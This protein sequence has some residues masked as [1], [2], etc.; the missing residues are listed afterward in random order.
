MGEPDH[1]THNRADCTPKATTPTPRR[2]RH[3]SGLTVEAMQS[4]GDYEATLDLCAWIPSDKLRLEDQAGT[5][6][7]S[8]LTI[9]RAFERVWLWDWVIRYEDGNFNVLNHPTFNTTFT[10]VDDEYAAVAPD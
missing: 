6:T 7:M 8:V 5:P 4:D 3:I 2:W 1:I 9:N 10:I